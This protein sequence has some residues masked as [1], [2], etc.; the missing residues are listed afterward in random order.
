MIVPSVRAWN[1]LP[2]HSMTS[3]H[4]STIF[5]NLC[6]FSFFSTTLSIAI[7]VDITFLLSEKRILIKLW[8]LFHRI[9]S[10]QTNPS[11]L[12]AG[13]LCHQLGILQLPIPFQRFFRTVTT[14]VRP[15]CGRKYFSKAQLEVTDGAALLDLFSENNCLY[16]KGWNFLTLLIKSLNLMPSL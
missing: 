12:T 7:V 9:C 16:F 8:C 15:H 5:L 3:K 11:S 13:V 4:F 1:F 6:I 14:S 10:S 2:V